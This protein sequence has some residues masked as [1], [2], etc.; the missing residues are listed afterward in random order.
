[1]HLR[2]KSSRYRHYDAK[3]LLIDNPISAGNQYAKA[4]G[5]ELVK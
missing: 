2:T 4:L 3:S 5:T 1:M